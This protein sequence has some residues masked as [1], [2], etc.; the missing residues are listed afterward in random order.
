MIRV[1][2]PLTKFLRLPYSKQD[3]RAPLYPL[4]GTLATPPLSSGS[5]FLGPAYRALHSPGPLPPPQPLLQLRGQNS[6][7]PSTLR[8]PTSAPMH[9]WV[10]PP[11]QRNSTNQAKAQHSH[12]SHKALSLRQACDWAKAHE[13]LVRIS[14]CGVGASLHAYNSGLMRVVTTSLHPTIL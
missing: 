3:L 6:R 12:K 1:P 10:P 14:N 5:V 4:L 13:P 9:T 8:C 7:S 2:E 11:G